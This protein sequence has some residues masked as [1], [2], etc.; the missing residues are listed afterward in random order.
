MGG[1]ICHIHQEEVLVSEEP[2]EDLV[3]QELMF[4]ELMLEGPV[5]ANFIK[6]HLLFFQGQQSTGIITADSG[7]IT[8]PTWHQ[9]VIRM[10]AF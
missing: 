3:T 9:V 4:V 10:Q 2:L 8:M 6:D 1:F 5:M 7:C